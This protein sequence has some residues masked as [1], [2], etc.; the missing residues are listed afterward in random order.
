MTQ[1]HNLHLLYSHSAPI[2]SPKILGL[3]GKDRM[4]VFTRPF[5]MHAYNLK[6]I[7]TLEEGFG[8]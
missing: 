1:W 4:G 2:N 8:E 5:P 6:S 7:S 3:I